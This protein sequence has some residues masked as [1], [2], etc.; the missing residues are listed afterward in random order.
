M[1]IQAEYGSLDEMLQRKRE[2]R[3]SVDYRFL[4]LV[5]I[6]RLFHLFVALRTWLQEYPINISEQPPK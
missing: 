1:T 5:L 3:V 6:R 4:E 2:G